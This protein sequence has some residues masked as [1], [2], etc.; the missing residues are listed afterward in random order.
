MPGSVDLASDSDV[1]ECH[2]GAESQ[3]AVEVME[4]VAIGGAGLEFASPLSPITEMNTTDNSPKRGD[5]RRKGA[6][7]Y[8]L[9]SSA[10]RQA[11]FDGEST[12]TSGTHQFASR[13]RDGSVD[14]RSVETD[15]ISSSSPV[16]DNAVAT[17]VTGGNT[18]GS[19]KE[20]AN[21]KADPS[22]RR[23]NFTLV[24]KTNESVHQGR[25][26]KTLFS[27]DDLPPSSKR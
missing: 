20:A 21:Q 12:G 22:P 17:A 2:L 4:H 18:L 26:G 15:I 23:R 9:C 7:E 11:S 13:W 16:R 3:N 14:L 27:A 10:V 8:R 1:D 25:A 6:P 5:V 19:T 24:G